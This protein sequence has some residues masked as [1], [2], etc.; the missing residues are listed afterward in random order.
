MSEI[1]R[2]GQL[3]P[4]RLGGVIV[5]S[6]ARHQVTFG[7]DVEVSSKTFRA[8]SNGGPVIL[9]KPTSRRM[10]NG[11]RKHEVVAFVGLKVYTSGPS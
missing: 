3:V 8:L 4:K 9:I 6:K 11:T 10:N 7:T 1:F 2:K 5:H